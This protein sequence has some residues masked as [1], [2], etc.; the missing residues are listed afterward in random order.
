MR[1]CCCTTNDINSHSV[2]VCVICTFS[3]LGSGFSFAGNGCR[4]RGSGG[5]SFGA[6]WATGQQLPARVGSFCISVC[7]N[8]QTKH[9]TSESISSTIPSPTFLPRAREQAGH[10]WL[11]VEMG[12]SQR[13]HPQNMLF[14]GRGESQTLALKFM[15][16]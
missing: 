15:K 2:E 7:L 12:M 11:R 1:N 8:E 16:T 3:Q 10:G 9:K 13:S 4:L 6:T 5:Q 14:G